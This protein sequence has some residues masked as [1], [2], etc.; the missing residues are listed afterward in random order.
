MA[1]SLILVFG[2][3]LGFLL[4]RSVRP[5]GSG[6]DSITGDFLTGTEPKGMGQAVQPPR[7]L[8]NLLAQGRNAFDRQDLPAAIDAFKK[9]LA[10]DPNQSE[11]HS[12]MGLILAQA[13]HYD[14]A[15]LA[16]DKALTT[17]PNLPLALWGKGMLLYRV[18]GDLNGARWH[19]EKL[20]TS[21]HPGAER[22]EIEKTLLEIAASQSQ[23]PL[24]PETA[25][26]QQ[27]HG[28]ISIDPKVKSKVDQQSVLFI[29][30]RPSGST[31]GPPLAVK[32]IPQ[33][34]FPLKYSLGAQDVMIAGSQFSGKVVVSARLDKDGNPTTRQPGDLA[35]EY[36][37][38]PVEVGAQSV[39]ILI[40]QAM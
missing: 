32:R 38:N 17:D 35:G 13:G 14:G 2:V 39:D 18:K 27:I 7:D 3:T 24:K 25:S 10:V 28:V 20:L 37:K 9:A 5:R 12:Y 8:S 40:N 36:P 6:L 19:L 4:A 1:G 34:V 29:I 16:F 30:A 11:A 21:V 31:A 15:L 23:K 22:N 33:P 26:S